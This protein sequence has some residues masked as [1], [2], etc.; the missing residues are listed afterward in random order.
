MSQSGK[1]LT[2]GPGLI[3]VASSVPF[4]MVYSSHSAEEHDI[5]IWSVPKKRGGGDS[6]IRRK[7]PSGNQRSRA[8][9]ES[10]YVPGQRQMD[11]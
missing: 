2:V 5:V 1:L 10:I 6:P 9:A 11:Y 8:Q 3:S 7:I 4:Q